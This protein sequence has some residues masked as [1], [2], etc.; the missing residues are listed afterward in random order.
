MREPWLKRDPGSNRTIVGLKLGK[1][2][3]AEVRDDG[4]NRT[5]V[6]LKRSDVS[7]VMTVRV[8]AIAPLWD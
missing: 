1:V 8:A 7:G 2:L 4:S 3:N 6:G 5:I